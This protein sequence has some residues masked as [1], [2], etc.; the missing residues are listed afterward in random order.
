M[1][2]VRDSTSTLKTS[3][4]SLSRYL[5]ATRTSFLSLTGHEWLCEQALRI[6]LLMPSITPNRAAVPHLHQSFNAFSRE[7]SNFH[8]TCVSIG[9]QLA[10]TQILFG[11]AQVGSGHLVTQ[12][13]H[14]R[15]LFAYI[16]RTIPWFR[17]DYH[18]IHGSTSHSSPVWPS[19]TMNGR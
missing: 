16:V 7:K 4:P 10:I 9:V 11:E 14:L 19:M 13:P 12:L 6:S 17:A 5:S 2:E 8:N 18:P 1:L 3:S 15:R